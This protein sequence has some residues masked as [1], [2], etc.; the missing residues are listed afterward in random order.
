MSQGDLPALNWYVDQAISYHKKSLCVIFV[1]NGKGPELAR[2]YETIGVRSLPE[3]SYFA[4]TLQQFHSL[5]IPTICLYCLNIDLNM[6]KSSSD[7]QELQVVH[8]PPFLFNNGAAC[9]ICHLLL[10]RSRGI[11]RPCSCWDIKPPRLICHTQPSLCH[12]FRPA[13]ASQLMTGKS[14]IKSQAAE[15]SNNWPGM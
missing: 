14:D 1:W 3:A 13:G 12:E 11:W 5:H 9:P 2:L 7:D 15:I 6:S 4:S 8:K 10:R